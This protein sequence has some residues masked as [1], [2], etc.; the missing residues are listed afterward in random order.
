LIH[1]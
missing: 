1:R